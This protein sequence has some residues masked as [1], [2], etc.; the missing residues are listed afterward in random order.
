MKT[1]GDLR[2]RTKILILEDETL[3][4]WSMREVLSLVGYDVVGVAATVSDALCLAENTRPDVVIVD[5]A[6][7][8][9][10][11]GIEGADL[12]RKEWGTEIIFLTAQGDQT[13]IDRASAVDSAGFL[14]KPVHSQQL[15]R[16]IRRVLDTT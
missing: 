4:A 3:L 14:V 11:D 6:L 5:V 16:A 12:L 9:R 13:T 8:G 7:A 10:R 15:V 1:G 2:E